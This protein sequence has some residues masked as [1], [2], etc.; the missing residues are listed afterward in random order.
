[1]AT[2]RARRRAGRIVPERTATVV[3]DLGLAVDAVD[4]GLRVAR[5]SDSS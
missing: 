4:D 5:A 3:D 1:V 2:L